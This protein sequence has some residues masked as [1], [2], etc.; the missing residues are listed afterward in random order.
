MDQP[1]SDWPALR[2]EAL[3][4]WN[5]IAA[6]WDAYMG[7]AGNDFHNQLIKPA[8]TRLLRPGPAMK[9]LELGCG[10]GLYA[11]DMEAM[12]ADVVATDGSVA[13]L[14]IA[15][16]RNAGNRVQF[17]ELDVTAQAHWDALRAR[18]P[19]FDGA[20][21]NMVVM[22]VPDFSVMCRNMARALRPGG[23]WVF[24]LMHPCFSSPEIGFV[25]ERSGSERQ[26]RNGVTIYRYLDVEPYRGYGIRSQPERHYYFHRPLHVIVQ[27]LAAC[28]FALNGMEEPAFAADGNEG[29]P[30]SWSSMP[31]I[32]PAM[33]LRARRLE[34]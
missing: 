31:H 29:Q 34:D 22:D 26:A 6:D 19:S 1:V 27:A 10:A 13:F 32:P 15:R 2:A 20:V 28:G 21:A 30:L 14:R 11:R 9:I 7:D 4:I 24:S 8:V 18:H 16:Q 12:G 3:R 23:V 17:A 33:I 5:D 25:A